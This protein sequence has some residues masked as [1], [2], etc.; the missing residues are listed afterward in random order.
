MLKQDVV[1][2]MPART[3]QYPRIIVQNNSEN[4]IYRDNSLNVSVYESVLCFVVLFLELI[5]Y[6]NLTLNTP[7]LS[8]Q[9]F[10]VLAV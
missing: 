4:N 3:E 5:T 1:G 10:Y 8:M 9:H 2:K 6:Y 7:E